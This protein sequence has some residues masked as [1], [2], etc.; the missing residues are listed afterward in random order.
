MILDE[1]TE[2][3]AP[4]IR[5]EIWRVLEHNLKQSGQAILVIDK[6]PEAMA[7][8]ADRHYIMDKGSLVWEGDSESLLNSSQM[9]EQYLGV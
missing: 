8:L 3:L 4:K 9:M 5:D 2:G 7:R 6:H 1:A